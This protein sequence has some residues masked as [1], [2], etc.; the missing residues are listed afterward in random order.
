VD[1]VLS[2]PSWAA[3]EPYDGFVQLFPEEGRPPTERTE[4][5]VLYDD[6]ALYV[7][8]RCADSDAASL[9]RPLGR[10]DKAPF[11]DSVAVILDS[12]RDRRTAFYFE[13]NAAGVQSDAL[14]F[15]E[16]ESNDD[17]DAVWDG[18]VTADGGGWTAEFLPDRVFIYTDR[19]EEDYHELVAGFRL[20][21]CLL[22]RGTLEDVFLKL[23]GRELRE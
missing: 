1:G 3:A 10:R 12:N 20:D 16:D 19:G 6:R 17:W 13:L 5:R 9:V 23:T 4:V 11:S 8:I 14:L 21:Q 2:E 18:A 22:R 7:G 15:G